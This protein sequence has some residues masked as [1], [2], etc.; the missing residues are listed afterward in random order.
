M[1]VFDLQDIG[2]CEGA[3]SP[4]IIV[5]DSCELPCG[6]WELNPGPLEEQTERLTSVPSFQP[7]NTLKLSTL[8]I[9]YYCSSFCVCSE[10]IYSLCI[11]FDPLIANVSVVTFYTLSF[12]LLCPSYFFS[13]ILIFNV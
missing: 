7:S 9:R 4:G 11:V 13:L 1:L 2:L 3:R 6:C 12:A 5:T 8:Q 10:N